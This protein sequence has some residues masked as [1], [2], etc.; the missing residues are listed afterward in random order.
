MKFTCKG[1]TTKDSR[2]KRNVQTAFCHQHCD[3]NLNNVTCAI[4]FDILWKNN[5]VVNDKPIFELPKCRHAFHVGCALQWITEN[6]SCPICRG[7]VKISTCVKIWKENN[8]L[9]LTAHVKRNLFV[10]FCIALCV[11]NQYS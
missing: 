3:Q 7:K 6:R 11:Y 4:C 1:I 9:S 2:C 5:H 8:E 10:Y